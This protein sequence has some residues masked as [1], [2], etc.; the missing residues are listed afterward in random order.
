MSDCIRLSRVEGTASRR[1]HADLPPSAHAT[2]VA[3]RFAVCTF[4]PRPMD[5]DPAALKVPFFHN[6]EDD[7]D[8]VPFYHRGDFFSRDGVDRGMITFHPC[9]FARGPHPKALGGMFTP[10]RTAT[11][12]YAVM[13]DTRDALEVGPLP[14]GVE[15][16]ANVKSWMPKKEAAE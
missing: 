14:E 1:A 6:N 15:N 4:C 16:H 5:M 13:L 12:E 8:E 9:G 2:F 10:R 3:R 11:D 7:S